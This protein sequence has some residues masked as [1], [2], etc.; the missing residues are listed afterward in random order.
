VQSF[1]GKGLPSTAGPAA[2]STTFSA[3]PTVAAG[4][5]DL[6]RVGPA[7]RAKGPGRRRRAKPQS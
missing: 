4:P 7:M 5:L 1:F 6:R 3:D 2:Q